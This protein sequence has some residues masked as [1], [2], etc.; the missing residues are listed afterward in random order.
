[1]S[2]IFVI[3]ENIPSAEAGEYNVEECLC[4]SLGYFTDETQAEAKVDELN[5]KHQQQLRER[6]LDEDDADWDTERFGFVFIEPAKDDPA[7]LRKV[8]SK[9]EGN[10]PRVT[11]SVTCGA[12]DDSKF[13]VDGYEL[14][15][16]GVIEWPDSDN[17][18]IRRRDIHGN[19]E[20]V[21]EHGDP[22]HWEWLKLFDGRGLFYTGQHVH[23]DGCSPGDGWPERI[24]ADGTVQD[25]DDD[26]VLVHIDQ[27]QADIWFDKDDVTY[28]EHQA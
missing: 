27:H 6:G 15:D 25:V 3:V 12:E 14:E 8:K 19:L 13:A 7:A 24:A 28:R 22:G 16:G 10:E 20:E 18:T 21:R 2:H 5:A 17:G 26:Q 9:I 1:M 4:K 11:E 23:V